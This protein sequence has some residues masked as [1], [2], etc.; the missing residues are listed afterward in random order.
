MLPFKLADR[1]L[2]VLLFQ[3]LIWNRSDAQQQK[4]TSIT[5]KDGLPS[6]FIYRVI[7]DNRGFLWVATDAGLARFDGKRFQVYTKKDGLPDDEVLSVEKEKNGTIWVNCFKQEPAYFDEVQNRF[8]KVLDKKTL[9]SITSTLNMYLYA[10][11][12]E[13][14]MYTNGNGSFVFIDKKLTIYESRKKDFRLLLIRKNKDGTE[15]RSGGGRDSEKRTISFGIYQ[16]R[17]NKI[18]DSNII[19]Y[20]S[21]ARMSGASFDDG[22][23]YTCDFQYKK[24]HIYSN[25]TTNPIRYKRDS[26]AIPEPFINILFTNTS[27]YFTA[28]SGKIYV[29]DKRTLKQTDV[30][31][32]NYLPNS[33][34]DDSQGNKWISTI[35]KGLLLYKRKPLHTIIMP[36]NYMRTNFL[37]I[38]RKKDGTILSGNYYGEVLETKNGKSSVH[39]ITKMV[40]S[41]VRKIILT[42]SNIYTFSEEGTFCNYK[43]PLINPWDGKLHRSKTAIIFNDSTLVIGTHHGLDLLNTRTNKVRNLKPRSIRITALAKKNEHFVYFGSLNGLYKYDMDKDTFVSLASTNS[44]LGDKVSA[45]CFTKDGILWVS[46]S[47][48]GIIAVKDDKVISSVYSG[49]TNYNGQYRSIISIEDGQLW[50][51]TPHGINVIN[52]QLKNN[53]LHYNIGNITTNDGLASNDVQ[54]LIYQEK[55]VY[56]ATSNGISIIPENFVLP[57]FNIPTLLI[58]MS[59]NQRD[60]IL[61]KYYDLKYNQQN[62]QMKFAGIDLS[63]HFKHFQ[64]TLDKNSNWINLDEHTLTVQLTSGLHLLQVRA[65]DVSGNISKHILTIKFNVATPFWK[66][67]WF[68]VIVALIFQVVLVYLIN[69]RQKKLKEARLSK[70]L[71]AVQTAALEQQAFTSLM[72][73]HFMFNALNSI[74]HYINVQ[75][76]QNANRYLSD[77]ASL[78]RKNFEAAQQSFIPLEEE[79]EHVKLYLSL[80]QMR[81]D[82]QFQY[83]V[84][85]SKDLDVEDWMIPTMILQPLLEN[86]LLHGLMPSNIPGKVTINF[87][88]QV[89]DLL[90]IITDNGIGLTNSNA[91]KG[92]STHKSRGMQ[93]IKKR[94]TALCSFGSQPITISMEPAFKSKK[95]PGNKITLLIPLAL[96]EAWLNAKYS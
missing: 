88:R 1:F 8:V 21:A 59:V 28:K 95:N 19:S 91:L 44:A 77:F 22:K 5:I 12:D 26:L 37:S 14:V 18:I 79:I 51:A 40:T 45:L 48:N 56:A 11:A 39:L 72:N 67:V 92:G 87:T 46:T 42:G 86:A 82:E 15:I 69:K 41:K 32:G 85:I 6:N 24:C 4:Y 57:K 58:H 65:V 2:I 80:E 90:I 3:L 25:F 47:G 62:V 52:Y 43:I 76:R 74:Q 49:S 68:W 16:T 66:S 27:L 36:D 64:Y 55:K 81:F 54:D 9:A 71:A 83:Q 94:I 50:A 73:P 53:K 93:L 33:Y 13:G 31:S 38:A 70:S 34:F 75:D 96:H 23:L 17:N 30:I 78:I 35:D 7:E 10:L 20:K 63:G 89:N 60:T 61:T 84:K 29:Y